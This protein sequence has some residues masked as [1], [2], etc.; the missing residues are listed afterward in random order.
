MFKLL[1]INQAQ[2]TR[3]VDL[4]NMETQTIDTCFDDS[5]LVSDDG[6]FEFMQIGQQYTCKL[7]L[8][9]STKNMDS[10]DWSEYKILTDKVKLGDRLLSKVSKADDIYY[11]NY[12]SI[13]KYISVG[14]FMFDCTRKDLI[15]VNNVIHADLFR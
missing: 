4:Q 13:E 15:Q 12:E 1:S 10:G 14:K 6:N 9:G 5:A 3:T 11:V 8:F 7:R 2:A